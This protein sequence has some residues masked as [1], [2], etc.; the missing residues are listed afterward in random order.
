MNSASPSYTATPRPDAD[1][2]L[3]APVY[4]L[5]EGQVWRL[6][7]DGKTQQQITREAAAVES[8]DV[9]PVDGALVYSQPVNR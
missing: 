5:R 2:E 4:F 6:A 9:S 8:F 7:R 1:L 3:P